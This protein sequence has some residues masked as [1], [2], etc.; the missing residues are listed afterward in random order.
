[1]PIPAAVIDQVTRRAFISTELVEIQTTTPIYVTSAPYDINIQTATSNGFQ[2]YIAQGSFL[3]FTGINTTDKISVNT[4][5]LTFTGATSFYTVGILND[6]YL[7]RPIRIYKLFLE[8]NQN[9]T[10]YITPFLI[11]EGIMTGGN[12]EE[13]GNSSVVTINTNN[14]FYDFERRNGRR[15]N[16]AS[17]RR[18]FPND[19]GMDYSTQN[20]RDIVWGRTRT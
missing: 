10:N 4:I 9:I 8:Q 20:T 19:A 17:H 2:K 11:Y 6:A 16:S 7:H 15:T 14:H 12:I 18:I 3:S 13:D 5:Q 1:M